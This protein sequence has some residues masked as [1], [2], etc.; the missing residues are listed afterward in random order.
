MADS[1][2]ICEDIDCAWVALILIREFMPVLHRDYLFS[3]IAWWL[4]FRVCEPDVWCLP[5]KLDKM[6]LLSSEGGGCFCLDRFMSLLIFELSIL[7]H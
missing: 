4:S 3:N 1:A 2:S 7:S 6:K 5:P